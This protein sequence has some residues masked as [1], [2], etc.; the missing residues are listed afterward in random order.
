MMT[1]SPFF[2]SASTRSHRPS[3]WNVRLERPPIARLTTFIFV[4]SKNCASSWPQPRSGALLFNV[5]SPTTNNVGSFGSRI[6]E[7]VVLESSTTGRA[8]SLT[9][10]AASESEN[11][12]VKSNVGNLVISV[13]FSLCF[14]D[15][16][17]VDMRRPEHIGTKDDPL[18]VGR[19]CRIR[20]EGVI[21]LCQVY[22]FLGPKLSVF[23][24]E[25]V[26]PLSVVALC[27]TVRPAA[28]A[29]ERLTV[30][31]NTEVDRPLTFLHSVLLDLAGFDVVF[32]KPKHLP[33]RRLQIVVDMLAVLAKELVPGDLHIH[34]AGV[35]LFEIAAVSTD[36]PDAVDLVPRAFVAE[37]YQR[38]VGWRH[39]NMIQPVGRGM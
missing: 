2:T 5:E 15:L 29:Q 7:G 35:D 11:K 31:R 10:A 16:D 32:G 13:R 37:H 28:V 14:C 6:C 33:F 9:C 26:D 20:F 22:Q 27:N 1:T 23:G 17:C 12:S 39:L 25:E 24:M 3:F 30:G 34:R 19:E 21:M 8:S 38:R 4:R 36:R 18:S